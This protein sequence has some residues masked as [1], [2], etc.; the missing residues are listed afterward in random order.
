MLYALHE[1]A[2]R[3]AAPLRL[4][5]QT[6]RDFWHSPNNLAGNSQIGRTLYA[7]SDLLANLTKQYGRPA[8]G[9]DSVEI[10]GHAVRVSNEIVWRSPWVNL[11]R[12]SR[13][14]IGPRPRGPL[15]S[16]PRRS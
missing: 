12:F 14:A 1:A 10:D 11:R 16:T 6:S 8:W 4:A 2:Y 15:P 7:S 13:D 3:A 9:I 5:A